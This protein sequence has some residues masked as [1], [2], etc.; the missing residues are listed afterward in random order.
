MP[1]PQRKRGTRYTALLLATLLLAGASFG[2]LRTA[3]AATDTVIVTTT[4]D[5]LD[6]D[7]ASFDALQRNR[8]ADG[9]ISLREAITAANGTTGASELAIEF[10]IPTG[11]A[12]YDAARKVW[13]IELADALPPLSR[14]EVE[15]D[16]S[17]QNHAASRPSVVLDGYNVFAPEGEAN[18]IT[19]TSANNVIR[20]LALANFWDVG[21]QLRGAGA[22]GNRLLGN[23]IGISPDEDVVQPNNH[24][25]ELRDG[26]SG[27]QI[28]GPAAQDRNIISGNET[29]GIHITGAGTTGNAVLGNWI[30][31]GHSGATPVGNERGVVITGGANGNSVGRAGAGNVI[32][33]NLIGVELSFGAYRNSVAGNTLG[34]GA[35]GLATNAPSGGEGSSLGNYDGGIFVM[36]AAYENT[37]GGLTAGERNVIA[38]NGIEGTDYGDGVYIDGTQTRGNKVLG[39]YI[40][41]NRTGLV[42][43]GNRRYGVSITSTAAGNYIGDTVADAGNVI[44]YNGRGGVRISSIAN[45]VAG[46]LIGVGS[47]KA[48]A[49][50]NQ[51]N[52]V[53]VDGEANTITNNLI[54]HNHLSGVVVNGARTNVLRNELHHNGH[55][56]ICVAGSETTVSANEVYRNGGRAIDR[57]ICNIEGGIVVHTASETNILTNV[58]H[59][60]SDVGI[61]I[62][63]GTGNRILTNS[64]RENDLAGILLEAGGNQG[65]APPVLVVTRQSV[66]GTGCPG[67]T[68]EVFSDH[69]DEGSNF[70]KSVVADQNGVFSTPIQPAAITEPNITDT[71]TDP[72]G[73]TSPFAAP[74]AIPLE[75][76]RGVDDHTVFLTFVGR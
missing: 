14:G 60:N 51:L 9:A 17:T 48:T 30:G 1:A 8:G 42:G 38:N 70:I 29:Y 53:D 56:G 4:A 61:R 58:V 13:T 31:L 57:S 72:A 16:A 71:N 47:D 27:N 62:S 3:S 73:N 24:G 12:G 11:D 67:C 34:L 54:A 76:P 37:V 68:I 75:D 15:I 22:R 52:G 18:G 6:G 63:G 35:D 45:L 36:F 2:P 69:G 20:R 33:A 10:E 55:S 49:L 39:N 64:I 50:G 65:I 40:G 74:R 7:A 41:V 46:N 44:A 25:V 43:V 19:I 66:S 59:D 26:A 5:T 23:V 32:S 21:V 28:G